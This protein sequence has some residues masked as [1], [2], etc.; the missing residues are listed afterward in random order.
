ML[1]AELPALLAACLLASLHALGVDATHTLARHCPHATRL[2]GLVRTVCW[3][4]LPP[5][6]C[7][8]E[9]SAAAPASSSENSCISAAVTSSKDPVPNAVVVALAPRGH[10]SP[11]ARKLY[12]QTNLLLLGM[13]LQNLCLV[14]HPSTGWP[15]GEQDSGAVGTQHACVSAQSNWQSVS[16]SCRH[17]TAA[18][19]TCQLHF[20][21]S[22]TP[23]HK[24]NLS[25]VGRMGGVQ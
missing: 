13:A 6:I 16:Q 21:A 8:R 24:M 20:A 18:T 4:T 14:S 25:E 2:G 1:L 15:V 22:A 3:V 11:S 10:S 23:L 9:S 17:G 19:V 7:T 5:A 12:W